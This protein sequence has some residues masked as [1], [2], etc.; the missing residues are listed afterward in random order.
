MTD[1][2]TIGIAA[3]IALGVWL[4]V[5]A[6]LA[7]ATHAREPRATPAT[8]TLGGDEPPAVVNLITNDWAVGRTAVPATL[9]DLAARKVVAF[10]RVAP[11]RFVVRV[12]DRRPA[13]LT[14][15]EAQVYDHVRGLASGGVVACEALTTG[16]KDASKRW[17]RDFRTAVSADARQRGLS[18]PRWD[19]VQLAVL[20][21]LALAPAGLASGA[22]AALPSSSSSSKSDDPG[23]LGV[24]GV[25]AILWVAL[26]AIP[27]SLRAERDTVAGLMTASRWLGVRAQLAGDGHFA[28]QPPT[29]VAIWDRL[30]S[31]GAAMGVAPGAVR[32]LSMGAES[33]TEAWTA[34]GGRWRGQASKTEAGTAYGGHWHVVQVKYPQRILNGWGRR[35]L[36]AIPLGLA[37]LLPAVIVPGAIGDLQSGNDGWA[38]TL[39]AFVLFALGPLLLFAYGA[40]LVWSGV[41][42]IGKRTTLEGEVLRRKEI[43][44]HNDSGSTTTAVYLAVYDGNGAELRA[45]RCTPQV[46][47]G[48]YAGEEVRATITPHLRHVYSV[49]RLGPMVSIHTGS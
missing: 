12:P 9:I 37:F 18:R 2:A 21:L 39:V 13:G 7:V 32:P 5:L 19:R 36:A 8:M 34:Y 10:E 6:V 28:D 24:L 15:Y 26:M 48:I 44:S 11:E 22:F 41:A 17:W 30:L 14:H 29:A 35:P 27:R 25:A 4:L 45:L 20:G 40:F 42:D 38:F 46:A 47:S 43:V 16:P 1:A 3:A 31:Y 33:E 49:E 23:V